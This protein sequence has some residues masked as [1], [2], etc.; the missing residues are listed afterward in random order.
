V[1][2]RTEKSPVAPELAHLNAEKKPRKSRMSLFHRKV[3][4][5]EEPSRGPTPMLA[6]RKIYAKRAVTGNRHLVP[7]SDGDDDDQP[8][9]N[10]LPRGCKLVRTPSRHHLGIV[11][12]VATMRL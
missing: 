6:D 1:P 12:T 10:F 4:E 8:V 9:A 5:D 3:V 2:A 7:K 11:R